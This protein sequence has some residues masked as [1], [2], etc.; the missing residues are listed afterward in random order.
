MRPLIHSHS[1]GLGLRA[2]QSRWRHDPLHVR[3]ARDVRAEPHCIDEEARRGLHLNFRLT[4][5][6]EHGK[7]CL[8]CRPQ[9]SVGSTAQNGG[10]FFGGAI[11]LASFHKKTF[12]MCVF[13]ARVNWNAIAIA[14]TGMR[15]LMA[16]T[17][18]G[19]PY[20]VY[21]ERIDRER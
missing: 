8:G 5:R 17:I 10:W 15:Y 14:Q 18:V 7:M 3:E 12:I 21:R 16:A 13:V 20:R 2:T 1:V 11:V 6:R 19:P 9:R 4:R